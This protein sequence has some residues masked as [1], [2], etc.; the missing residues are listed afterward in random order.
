MTTISGGGGNATKTVGGPAGSGA[1]S[2]TS[3]STQVVVSS[4]GAEMR[5]SAGLLVGSFLVAVML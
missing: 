1:S 4:D 3:T 2:A 5:F